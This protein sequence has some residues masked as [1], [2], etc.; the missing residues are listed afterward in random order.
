MAVT[1]PPG[2][3]AG[4][5]EPAGQ[6]PP[7]ELEKA[8]TGPPGFLGWL[9]AVNHKDIGKRFVVTAFIFLL[10]GGAEALLLR[11]QLG[12]AESSLLSPELYNQ[13]FTM[14]GTTMMF[15]FAVPILEG[16]AMYLVPLKIGTRDMPFPRLNAFGYWCYL[17]G[18][19]LLHW[20]FLTGSVPDGGWFAYTPLSGPEFSPGSSLD[21]WLL[22][23]TF[24]EV[25]GIV[26]ALEL[27]VLI[28]KQRAPG[29]SL[30][31]MPLFVWSVLVMSAMML[32]AFPAVIAGTVLLEIE[33]KFGVPFYDPGG[34]GNPLLWQHLFWIFGH[35]EVYIMLVPATGI[36][37]AVVAVHTRRP[38]VA[39]PLVVA[40]LVAI[41]ILSF[42]LWAHHMF[43][44]GLPALV[45]ML[46][47]V[48][49]IFI[50]VPSGVQVFAWIATIWHGRPRWDTPLLFV[51]GFLVIF[52]LGGITGV[53]VAAAPFDFQAHDSYFV[54][55]HFHYVLLGGVLF[56]VFAGLHHWFP[57]LTGR[58][59]SERAGKIAFWSIFAGF[60][61]TFFP[62]HFLGLLG[63]PR[64]VYT[65]HS[66]LGWEGYNLV[67][68][69]G[70]FLLAAGVAVF[71]WNLAWNW[72][73][74]PAAGDDPWGGDSLEWA[75]ASPP[76]PYNFRSMPLV[77][78]RTPR[79]EPGDP[80]LSPEV[81]AA[82]AR[83]SEPTAGRREQ[84]RT[85]A[86]DAVPQAV[87]T[88]PGPTYWPLVSAA[89][90]AVVLV[91]ILVESVV[92]GAAG[93]AGAVVALVGWLAPRPT[94]TE[95]L[96]EGTTW[97][98]QEMPS[99]GHRG[100]PEAWHGT[101]FG[102]ASLGA[103]LGALLYAYFYL[104]VTVDRWPPPGTALP[105]LGLPAVATAVLMLAVLPLRRALPSAGPDAAG[106]ARMG[107]RALVAIG[108]AFVVVDAAALRASGLAIDA[109]AYDGIF[110]TLHG[111]FLCLLAPGVI[112]AAVLDYRLG[113]GEYDSQAHA[114]VQVVTVWWWFLLLSWSAV[115]GTLYLGPRLL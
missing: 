14:H 113:H 115:A 77:G 20:S 83:L 66:G 59:P 5:P 13:I 33:R 37:S 75:T 104:S 29:M 62:Q 24:V 19:V 46:F 87:F 94:E 10:V 81:E 22:G 54:V 2:P 44:V 69:A 55:A 38:V 114:G 68:T 50:A 85:S 49:S 80:G 23:V 8:W 34:G 47:A 39:Y 64:R 18:G 70:A 4:P 86:I 100:R 84:L 63:M 96:A 41:G 103:V 53:M 97:P 35:P 52:V 82:V 40:S 73:R 67:S 112:M 1:S 12:T 6:A 99:P 9:S 89:A 79:W 108:A 74:G 105:G 111:F 102:A 48:A 30:S 28:L 60:N 26:G 65:Y 76:P 43:T 72:R 101:V 57:K 7:D 92:I 88:V 95:A 36:V 93:L 71:A 27:L 110:I 107:L 58:R 25:S 98:E 3:P 91:G 31:R 109:H 61:V 78:S 17:F 42:G 21:Y 15:L 56:P 11:L 51:V 16:L 90:L 45:L 32:L 106:R